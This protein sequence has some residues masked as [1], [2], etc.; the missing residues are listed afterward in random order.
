M[1]SRVVHVS[2]TARQAYASGG[3]SADH[4]TRTPGRLQGGWA[5]AENLVAAVW[6]TP[7]SEGG[8]GSIPGSFPPRSLDS[9]Y[10]PSTDRGAS[11]PRTRRRHS[12]PLSREGS[13]QLVD[14]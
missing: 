2:V 3:V 4:A 13:G 9:S 5:P 8:S 14:K 6:P 1:C 11:R 10:A 7:T 12:G